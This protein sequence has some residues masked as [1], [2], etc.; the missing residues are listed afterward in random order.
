MNLNVSACLV[1]EKSMAFVKVCKKVMLKFKFVSVS[2]CNLS[3]R[4]ERRPEAEG[5]RARV[6]IST[7]V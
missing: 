7:G 4:P 1:L 6:L 3:P 2:I 5:L